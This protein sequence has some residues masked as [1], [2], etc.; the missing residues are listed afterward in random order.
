[1]LI[2]IILAESEVGSPKYRFVVPFLFFAELQSEC[3]TV[4]LLLVTGTTSY[5]S[6]IYKK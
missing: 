2:Y 1:M 6:F 3:C 4:V 5:C